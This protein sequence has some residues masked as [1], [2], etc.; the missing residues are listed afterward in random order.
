MNNVKT[1]LL[2]TAVTLALS[3][4]G[5]GNQSSDVGNED[6]LETSSATD[7][8]PIVAAGAPAIGY[9]LPTVVDVAT[10]SVDTDQ[11]SFVQVPIQESE[12]ESQPAQEPEQEFEQVPEPAPAS[13]P[14]PTPESA[15]EP[16][17]EVEPQPEPEPVQEP[18]VEPEPAAER[19]PAQVA[20]EPVSAAANEV[21]SS[22]LLAM[23]PLR[24]FPG[25][26]G[27]GTKTVAG[28]GGE[29]CKVT[30]LADSGA[31]T[32][33]SCVERSG[34]RVVVF[35]VGGTIEVSKGIRLD[36]PYISI[37]GQTAPGDGIMLRGSLTS[38][39][40]PMIVRSHDVLIQHMRIRAGSSREVTCC[41]D[42]IAIGS[43]KPGRVYNVVLDHNSFAWGIDEIVDIW[44][45]THDVTL[46]YN[47]IAESL[48]DNGSND[49]GPAGRGLVV[50]SNGAHSISLHHNLIAHSYQRNPLIKTSGIVDVTNNLVYHYVSRAAQQYEGYN[51]QK[52]NWVKNKY[53]SL[54][55]QS[56]T[57]Q[58]SKVTWGDLLLTTNGKT[59]AIYLED[60]LGHN[61]S[62][63]DSPQTSFAYTDWNKPYQDSL[64]YHTS[65]RFAAPPVKEYDVS[66]LEVALPPL[67]GATLPK[68]DAVDARIIS[69]LES[70]S[71]KM[72]NCVA[73]A[74]RPGE[75]RCDNNVGGWPRL[76]DGTA[77]ADDD[78]DGM[79]ND[80]EIEFGF[81]PNVA[82]GAADANGDGYTNLE[83]YIHSIQ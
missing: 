36:D 70:R 74:D 78:N 42:A 55:N 71:G 38:I 1:V 22:D 25:A 61:R 31:G 34:P 12:P 23:G 37:Y 56:D 69:E 27:F 63:N 24:V 75:A 64:G 26:E 14:E 49:E 45:D 40:P 80:W 81:N 9:A 6:L 59:P 46:S 54:T 77:P 79:P 28:R 82:D 32:L 68:R 43:D 58:D 15:P 18:D 4:C 48:H 57:V 8:T 17:P 5:S 11:S 7:A 53:I 76:A 39:E 62:S 65:K 73:K 29:V 20:V 60:N 30:S 10:A 19:T 21:G 66:E 83:Q 51:G 72:P 47:I 35:E 52:V 13:E 33:R 50:G 41:R 44:F 67:V 2:T 16:E 3:A